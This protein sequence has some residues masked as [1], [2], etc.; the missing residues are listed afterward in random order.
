MRLAID[1][2]H[3]A[4]LHVAD[5]NTTSMNAHNQVGELVDRIAA[6]GSRERL[7]GDI[8]RPGAGFLS[9]TIGA[10]ETNADLILRRNGRTASR[11]KRPHVLP[12][13]E[14]LVAYLR[15]RVDRDQSRNAR[16]VLERVQREDL[17]L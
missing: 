3:V 15:A 12:E 7:D 9:P 4:V 13:H 11:N 8:P 10:I 17:G 2:Q 14:R 6:D 1:E 5:R 16:R